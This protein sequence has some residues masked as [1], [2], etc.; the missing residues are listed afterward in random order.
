M[1][2]VCSLQMLTICWHDF[3]GVFTYNEYTN[4]YF[5]QIFSIIEAYVE[6]YFLNPRFTH[7]INELSILT[8]GPPLACW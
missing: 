3:L 7:V 6:K 5:L 8:S 4:F 2:K 1:V